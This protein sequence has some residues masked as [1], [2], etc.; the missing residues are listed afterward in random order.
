MRIPREGSS[1]RTETGGGP[2]WAENALLGQRDFEVASTATGEK[3]ALAARRGRGAAN[4]LMLRKMSR[5]KNGGTGTMRGKPS[6]RRIED[7]FDSQEALIQG[8]HAE[9]L[10]RQ[11]CGSA[12]ICID[13]SRQEMKK[14]CSPWY[15]GKIRLR[16]RLRRRSGVWK[17]KDGR[18]SNQW[19]GTSW[20][21]SNGKR[22]TVGRAAGPGR[23][24]A[25]SKDVRRL[26]RKIKGKNRKPVEERALRVRRTAFAPCG[27]NALLSRSEAGPNGRSSTGSN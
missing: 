3:E 21:G 7:S 6:P 24:S 11:K 27:E 13:P 9:T 19:E 5:V 15:E 17:M 25:C 18:R 4:S 12:R 20:T 22:E 23:R 2:Q 16:Y 8:R 26:A 14:T 1:L 10:S